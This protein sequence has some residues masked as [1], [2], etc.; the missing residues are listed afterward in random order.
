MCRS[1][2][3]TASTPLFGSTIVPRCMEPSL[4]RV[5]RAHSSLEF[6]ST[7]TARLAVDPMEAQLAV[8]CGVC[9]YCCSPH[10]ESFAVKRCHAACL[11]AWYSLLWLFSRP[12]NILLSGKWRKSRVRLQITLESLLDT[13]EAPRYHASEETELPLRQSGNIRAGYQS[14]PKTL[15]V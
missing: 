8:Q 12:S 2:L 10:M 3:A 1:S 4:F 5:H 14:P 13:A 11:T 9:P 15:P 7:V 6:R